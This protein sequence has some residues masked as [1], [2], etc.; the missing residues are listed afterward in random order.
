MQSAAQPISRTTKQGGFTLIE[1]MIVVAI[2][3]VLASLAVPQYQNYTARAQASEALTITGGLRS[4]IAERYA[5]EGGMPDA[6]T[7]FDIENISG[8]YVSGVDY[9]ESGIEVIFETDSAL[10]GATMLIT[11]VA[12][13]DDAAEANP[14]NGWS[15]SWAA[16]STGDPQQNWLPAGCRADEGESSEDGD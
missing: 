8:R 5:L 10:R 3:G 9:T 1:L 12:N 2:I 13:D 6:N 4:D 7:N 15:C 11:P 14:G 16:D